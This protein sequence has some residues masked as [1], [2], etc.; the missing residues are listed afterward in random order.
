MAQVSRPKAITRSAYL[1]DSYSGHVR[2][3]TK[4]ASYP[5]SIPRQNGAGY[6]LGGE[7]GG[8]REGE[9]GKGD[10]R[11]SSPLNT[12]LR[13]TPAA[14][15]WAHDV[16]GNFSVPVRLGREDGKLI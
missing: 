16:S 8:G 3:A 7:K 6:P 14:N 5:K 11:L 2:A 10:G 1:A 4:G 13:I 15:K 9:R 12:C